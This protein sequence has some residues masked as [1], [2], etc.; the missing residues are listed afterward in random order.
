MGQTVEEP[1]Q[2]A[3][4]RTT[5]RM[6]VFRHCDPLAGLREPSQTDPTKVHLHQ[7]QRH[8]DICL[9][10]KIGPGSYLAAVSDLIADFA[11]SRTLESGSL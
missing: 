7:R 9:S 4:S 3:T 6:P 2:V 5:P 10:S 8:N 11:A 1:R